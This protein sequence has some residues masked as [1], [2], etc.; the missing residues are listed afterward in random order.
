M[1]YAV[2]AL[3]STSPAPTYLVL[4]LSGLGSLRKRVRLGQLHRVERGSD[5]TAKLP[6]NIS[7][8]STFNAGEKLMNERYQD[9]Q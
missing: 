7:A 4:L 3:A 6:R 5:H 2:D 9:H 1:P 8:P